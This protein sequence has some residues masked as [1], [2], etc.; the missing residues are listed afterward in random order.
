[1]S[2][3]EIQ[4]NFQ[5]DR[6]EI[7][8]PLDWSPADLPDLTGKVV[9]VTGAAT[10]TG[11]GGNIA[12]QLALKG[13]KV[14]IG[15]RSIE[16]A[17]AGIKAILALSPSIAASN[18]KPFVADIADYRAVKDAADAFIKIEDRLDILVNNAGI[19]PP[20][21]ELDQYGVNKVMATNH[22]GHFLLTKTLLPLLEKTARSGAGADV[23]IVNVSSN[24]QYVVPNDVSFKTLAG[25]NNDFGGK[26]NSFSPFLVYGYSKVANILYTRELQKRLDTQGSSIIVT[27]PHPGSVATDGAS[28]IMGTDSDDWKAAWTPSDGALTEVW[29]AAHPEVREK[30]EQFKGQY[31]MPFGGLKEVIESAR[32]EEQAKGLWE[33]SEKVLKGVFGA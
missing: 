15:G 18:L 11:I 33:V 17:N 27:A 25:W 12:N 10:L 1:M 13:A 4:E 24:A 28:R 16:R 29:C 19:L 21:M 7:V 32:S 2:L 30:K 3:Q 9:I 20:E 5:V 6:N 8:R 31:I 23:R 22:L 26:E 14:Y